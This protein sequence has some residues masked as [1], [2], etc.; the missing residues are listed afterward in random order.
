[1]LQNS[2]LARRATALLL[3]TQ[4]VWTAAP[5]IQLFAEETPQSTASVTITQKSSTEILGT[6][7]LLDPVQQETKFS[8]AT[9]TLSGLLPGKYTLFLK[10]PAGTETAVVLSDGSTVLQTN[11]HPQMSFDMA[12]G[13]PYTI[14]ITY[15]LVYFGIVGAST[16]PGGM[17]FEIK[18]P[19]GL[20]RTGVAPISYE[21]MPIGDYNIRFKPDG[22]PEPPMKSGKLEKNKRLYFTIELQCENYKPSTGSSSSSSSSS[23]VSS[24]SSSSSIASI[25][26]SSSSQS[27]SSSVKPAPLSADLLGN[28][29]SSSAAPIIAVSASATFS[30]EFRDVVIDAWYTTAVTTVTRSGIFEGYKDPYGKL[31]GKFGPAD[32]VRI[33]E[34]AKIMQKL[35]NIKTDFNAMPEN[36]RARN[37]WFS[38]YIA[39]AETLKWPV[40]DDRHIDPMRPA[41]RAEVIATLL[42]ALAIHADEVSG[43]VFEDVGIKTPYGGYIEAAAKL[44]FVTGKKGPDGSVIGFDPNASVTRAEVAMIVARILDQRGVTK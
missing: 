13:I 19:D 22:C 43:T 21:K 1:M 7:T 16:V 41:T 31:T 12:S 29:F 9:H 20:V 37:A 28:T 27:S 14:S 8:D 18:G 26:S 2:T 35:G 42:P 40:F 33:S 44:G 30:A 17:P 10:A 15:N 36:L 11:N 39:M 23:S 32:P 24:S 3:S 38:G 25:S 34:I 5:A 4:I 6:W